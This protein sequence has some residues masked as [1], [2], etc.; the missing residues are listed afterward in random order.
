MTMLERFKHYKTNVKEIDDDHYELFEKLDEVHSHA[1]EF[2]RNPELF[3]ESLKQLRNILFDHFEHEEKVMLE[4]NYKHTN[5]H[6]ME[7][8]ELRT[9][10][11]RILDMNPSSLYYVTTILDE[12][13]V[14]IVKHIDD[15][16]IPSEKNRGV[17]VAG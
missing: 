1:K 7:H 8:N 11:S 12:L 2:K 15:W 10:M 13:E 9:R 16:D 5:Y 17:T 4:K 14:V 6:K 3:R